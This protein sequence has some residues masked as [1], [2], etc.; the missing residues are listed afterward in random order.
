M[1]SL[2]GGTGTTGTDQTVIIDNLNYNSNGSAAF[3]FT[4][5]PGKSFRLTGIAWEMNSSSSVAANGWINIAGGSTSVRVDHLHQYLYLSGSTGMRFGGSVTGVADHDFFDAL[6]G[7]L[8]FD[9]IF[10]NGE[11]WGAD[12]G[13]YGD[14]SWADTDHWGSSEFMYVEDSLFNN[15][16]TNDAHNGTRYAIRHCTITNAYSF[17]H[18]TGGN[19]SRSSRAMEIY[20]NVFSSSTSVGNAFP[21]NGGTL[22]FWGNSTNNYRYGTYLSLVRSNSA[23]YPETY[24]PGGWGYC[25]TSTQQS[26]GSNEDSPWDGNTNTSTGYPCLDDSGRGV[27]QMV[28][29]AFPNTINTATGTAAWPNQVLDPVY[30]WDNTYTTSFNYDTQGFIGADG[31]FTDNLDYYRQFGTYGEPGTFNGTKGVGQ[32]SYSA[33]PSSCT[34]G[35]G[36]WA[37]DQNTLYVCNPT[38]TW[39]AYYTPYTYPHPLTQAGIAPVPPTNVQAVGH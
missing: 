21:I 18:G 14:G 23:T 36:Y 19:R 27:G 24:P 4:T 26:N 10:N 12:T 33:I 7:I 17:N 32:G 6:P 1:S 25:G 37:T 20:Q 5:T 35:V 22:L 39:T 2:A 9:I 13:G 30:V 15:G 38:N 34:K 8:T 29:G 11:N 28:T 3:N 31:S 16:N